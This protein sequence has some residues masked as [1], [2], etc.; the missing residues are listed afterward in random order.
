MKEK[1]FSCLFKFMM[2]FAVFITAIVFF[3][4]TGYIINNGINSLNI[5][6]F[7]NIL[8]NIINTLVI[9]IISVIISIPIGISCSIYL[10]EYAKNKL[11]IE[12]V[13][14]AV[15]SLSA[16]PSILYGLFGMIFFVIILRLKWSL[17]S[18]GL[19]LSIMI[20]PIVIKVVLESLKMVP[21]N[22]REGSLSLGASKIITIMK[23]VIPSAYS[24]I[25]TA[26]ILSIGRI[27][28]ETAAVFLTSGTANKMSLNIFSS[29]R[30][31]SVH[32]YLLAKESVGEKAFQ[33]AFGTSLF[34]IIIIFILI[35]ITEL[36]FKRKDI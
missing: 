8:P 23:I 14:F 22:F 3:F 24:G 34:L 12:I 13:N 17:L 19:T 29:G 26:I 9:I 27:V 30:T 21:I 4:L 1:I 2:Y 32:L 6:F 7:I 20:L 25:A 33:D 11:F 35:L 18:G 31:L 5:A 10:N 28:G 36:L 16:I 15:D